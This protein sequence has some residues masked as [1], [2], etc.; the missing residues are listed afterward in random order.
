MDAKANTLQDNIEVVFCLE[1]S[2]V[3]DNS[4]MRDALEQVDLQ[5]QLRDL[6]FRLSGEAYSFHCENPP[7]CDIHCT[8]DTA[9]L[10]TTDALGKLLSPAK[11]S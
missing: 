2:D 8:V 5:C 3:A 10:P 9:E 7:A 1:Q 4:G 11:I 6:F